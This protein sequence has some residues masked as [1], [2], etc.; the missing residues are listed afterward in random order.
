MRFSTF[1]F[2]PE[3]IVTRPQINTPIYFQKYFHFL[4]DIHKNSIFSMQLLGYCTRRLHNFQVWLPGGCGTS[5]LLYPE[6]AQCP[7]LITQKL[8]NLWVKITGN[9]L[10]K[11]YLNKLNEIMTKFDKISEYCYLY[12]EVVQP[13]GNYTLRLHNLGV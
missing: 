7:D 6:V 2:F 11:T 8:Y 3:S 10:K 13:P 1:V 12:M 4:G 9:C 5:K